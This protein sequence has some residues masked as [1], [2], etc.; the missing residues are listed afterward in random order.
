MSPITEAPAQFHIFSGLM[1]LATAIGQRAY[2]QIADERKYLNLWAV[3]VGS[4]GCKKSTSINRA[5]QVLANSG[6]KEYL[7]PSQI[8][9][10]KL[11]P[12]LTER[13]VGTFFWSEWGATMDQWNKSYAQ[14]TMSIF[15]ALYDG[16]YFSRWLKA[17]KYEIMNSSISLFCGC[18]PSWLKK[19]I[20]QG[21]VA[22]GFWPRFLFIPAIKRDKYLA[23]P[24][25]GDSGL[26][27]HIRVSLKNIHD[28]FP[29]EMPQEI[30][31]SMVSSLYKDW[32]DRANKSAD[33]DKAHP[34]MASFVV[35]LSDY[36]KKISA[37]VEISR[38]GTVKISQEAMEYALRL[39]DWLG[40]SVIYVMAETEKSRW[41]ELEEQIYG[42]I[43]QAGSGGIQHGDL[44]HRI[45]NSKL[46]VE[47]AIAS[48]EDFGD[49][50]VMEV[51]PEGRGRPGKK[52]IDFVSGD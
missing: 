43:R 12:M 5:Q 46:E 21:D 33:E 44:R 52:Y 36:A 48:L 2:F 20:N 16:S 38:S 40:D 25:K 32:Y 45:H 51:K 23:T 31:F 27:E 7:F 47:N 15:T 34:Y 17:D 26:L 4:S 50:V 35:R 28:R 30:D 9:S 29:K 19:T 41:N 18:T 3:L 14:D 37:L 42:I 8:T 13:N 6:F 39:I 10:E 1:M 22:M 11:I 24:P 49:I